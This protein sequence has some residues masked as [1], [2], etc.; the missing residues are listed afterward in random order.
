MTKKKIKDINNKEMKELCFK[1]KNC[2]ECPL[3]RAIELEDGRKIRGL[4]YLKI[5]SLLINEITEYKRLY[6]E[7]TNSLMKE[8]YE[9]MLND[10]IEKYKKQGEN[11]IE[12]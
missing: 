4:C 10:S 2:T 3:K 9:S 1:Q 7:E 8:Y 5:R 12:L 11:E 6:S